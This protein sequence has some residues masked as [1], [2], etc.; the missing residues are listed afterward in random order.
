MIT[1]SLSFQKIFLLKKAYTAT[2]V[3]SRGWVLV[4]E[5]VSQPAA[6]WQSDQMITFRRSIV[7]IF[8]DQMSQ[9]S[10][11]AQL[12]DKLWRSGQ[13]K[14]GM[15]G[16]KIFW[17]RGEQGWLRRAGEK[18]V[19]MRRNGEWQQARKGN[20]GKVKA[21]EQKGEIGVYPKLKRN[22]VL[23]GGSYLSFPCQPIWLTF[24]CN[25][26]LSV[27]SNIIFQLKRSLQNKTW[28]VFIS[29]QITAGW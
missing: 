3:I 4:E 28:N 19:E 2:R 7:Q 1:L 25:K 6:P 8:S 9:L 18:E 26:I 27:E 5:E 23:V 17:K 14:I 16:E 11:L 24:G 10:T 12:S 22:L 20:M 15:K 29:S 13:L 21:G